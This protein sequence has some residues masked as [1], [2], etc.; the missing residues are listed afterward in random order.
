MAENGQSK[1]LHWARKIGLELIVIIFVIGFFSQSLVN[2][3]LPRVTSVPVISGQLTKSYRINGGVE[4]RDLLQVR[5]GSPVVID[6]YYLDPGRRVSAGDPVFRI[7]PGYRVKGFEQQLTEKMS[8]LEKERLALEKLAIDAG[9]NE[10][11]ISLL[12]VELKQAEEKLASTKTL[13]ESGAVSEIELKD[14]EVETE[15]RRILWE[16]ERL[17][18]QETLLSRQIEAKEKT[19]AITALQADLAQLNRQQ[20]F[21]SRIDEEGVYYAEKSGMITFAAPSGRVLGQD[22]TVV[23]IANV[24]EE[25]EGLI[26]RGILSESDGKQFDFGDLLDINLEGVAEAVRIKITNLF[27][28]ADADVYRME[29]QIMRDIP[30]QVTIRK[31]YRGEMVR[32]E[33]AAMV[34]PRSAI[35]GV[36]IRPGEK[37]SVYLLETEGGILGDHHKVREAE[38]TIMNVGDQYISIMGLEGVERPRV[39]TPVTHRVRDG[40][41][42]LHGY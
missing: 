23:T 25:M 9:G 28:D 27:Y 10:K 4:Y 3:T 24:N 29:G 22:D 12:E 40:V 42:V 34:V 11:Q 14:Q 17:R 37:G 2:Y 6:E 8:E 1:L 33:Q 19:L 13:F 21:Y 18:M 38:V 39:I 32:R 15:R 35:R 30:R 31:Q 26:Y 41:K 5:L 36:E 16:M 20:H 7:N